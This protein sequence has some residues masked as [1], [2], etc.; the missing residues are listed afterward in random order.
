[1]KKPGRE[2]DESLINLKR[3]EIMVVFG[4]FKV[5]MKEKFWSRRGKAVPLRADY[6]QSKSP[7]GQCRVGFGRPAGCCLGN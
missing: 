2:E 5:E 7:L 3:S 4:G 6:Y 1:M